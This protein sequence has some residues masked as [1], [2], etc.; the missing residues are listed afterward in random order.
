VQFGTSW[1]SQ[2]VHL[3]F[4]DTTWR[5]FGL[6]CALPNVDKFKTCCTTSDEILDM[7][8]FRAACSVFKAVSS[9]KPTTD[10]EMLGGLHLQATRDCSVAPPGS[11]SAASE[12]ARVGLSLD[13]RG[14]RRPKIRQRHEG[15]SKMQ[16]FRRNGAHVWIAGLMPSARSGLEQMS[17]RLKLSAAANMQVLLCNLLPLIKHCRDAANVSIV[18][19]ICA[20]DALL[21]FA[22]STLSDWLCAH[23]VLCRNIPC[24]IAGWAS[25]RHKAPARSGN[26]VLRL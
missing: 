19:H 5:L 15:I 4:T 14:H 25:M 21:T 6:L 12:L 7:S 13:M 11:W 17:L 24:S 8:I 23:A 2:I 16:P 22:C 20:C 1:G 3:S 26:G 18:N 10:R 9:S